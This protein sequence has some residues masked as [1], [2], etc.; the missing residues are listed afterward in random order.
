MN[1]RRLQKMGMALA[2]V[3]V[4]TLA[5]G[6]APAVGAGFNSAFRN[7]RNS[8]ETGSADTVSGFR[9]WLSG[10]RIGIRCSNDWSAPITELA[11]ET[12][13]MTEAAVVEALQTGAVL[14]ELAQDETQEWK[15]KFKLIERM[16]ELIDQAVA[17]GLI[18]E[19]MAM[20]LKAAT[21]SLASFLSENGGGPYWGKGFLGGKGWGTWRNETAVF[22]EMTVEDLAVALLNGTS[23]GDLTEGMGKDVDE[24]IDILLADFHQ[25]VDLMVE[26][27]VL[28]PEQADRIMVWAEFILGRLIYTNGPCSAA[29]VH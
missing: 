3:A 6:D 23:L 11:A 14:I 27:G 2:G 4:L 21:P 18:S 9:F 25:T 26:N 22:L 29:A 15:F 13:E 24:L 10:D 5:A 19:Q 16:N 7:H 12:F 17:Q 8:A 1:M 28:T 20:N